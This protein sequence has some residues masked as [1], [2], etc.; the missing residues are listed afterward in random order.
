MM[1][2]KTVEIKHFRC[3]EDLRVDLQQGLNVLVG[4][5]N[6]GKTALLYAI[7]HALG[8]SAARGDSLWLDRDD[9][10]RDEQNRETDLD[11]KLPEISVVLTFAGLDE[12]EQAFF[13]EI[14][15]FDH[16]DLQRSAAVVRFRAS[17]HPDRQQAFIRRT[18]GAETLGATEVPSQILAALPVT[19]LPALRD[20]EACLAPGYRNRLALMLRASARRRGAA[21]REAIESIFREANRHLE[22][23]ELITDARNS[24]SSTV[25]NLAGT[26]YTEPTIRAAELEFER[27]LRTLQ[28]QMT[29]GPVDGLDANG[30]GYNN[31][32]YIAVVLEHLRAPADEERPLLLV[33]EP[34]AHLH[35]QLTRLLADFLS[36]QRGGGRP[37][38]TLVSTHSPSL[39]ASV[40]V[41]S[42]HLMFR[43]PETLKVSCNS[44][45][46]AGLSPKEARSVKRMMDVTRASM[47][48]AKGVIL[49]EGVCEALLIPTLAAR[50][51]L[52][53]AAHHVAVIPICGVAFET[54]DKLL[55]PNMFGVPTAIVTD[56]DPAVER[57]DG[58]TWR[59]DVPMADGEGFEVSGRT[60]ALMLRFADRPN[61][62]VLHS[63]VTLEFDLAE[64]GEVNAVCMATAWG[65]C[66]VGTPGTLTVT[67]V[68]KAGL[69]RRAR[70]LVVWRGVCR[71]SSTA[72]K[73]ELA[74]NLAE[75]LR[76]SDVWPT[77]EVP[78]YLAS[79]IR[80]VMPAAVPV[81]SPGIYG[82]SDAAAL[83]AQT[84][85]ALVPVVPTALVTDSQAADIHAVAD[86]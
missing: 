34:E 62:R 16:A 80:H 24:L 83:P 19:F 3:L 79:A 31:L 53:L 33:E 42:V 50:H 13:Y 78:T 9:F 59:D 11:V 39:V 20:A 47:Y 6:V 54:F 81:E 30:L 63:K 76:D 12:A 52:D 32:L 72:S 21:T 66:F 67:D 36:G 58:G 25:S 29:G 71:A 77:F 27:I 61:V 8:P 43:A 60:K 55:G 38:Q 57:R 14:V 75:S 82:H 5:N 65:D 41:E 56:A 23:N 7:R 17:W 86:N 1:Y 22:Q 10:W 18:G 74:Q 64:A 45:A 26:D 84:S 73:A 48:F 2:L 70:A 68:T 15:D 4:R 51:G 49:V 85:Q 35:P 69:S 28:V 46:R 44:L 40:P 37:P